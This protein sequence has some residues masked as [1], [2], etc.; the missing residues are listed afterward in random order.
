MLA[1]LAADVEQTGGQDIGQHFWEASPM[2]EP[3]FESDH[4]IANDSEPVPAGA[5]SLPEP[6]TTADPVSPDRPAAEEDDSTAQNE[7]EAQE[8]VSDPAETARQD[9]ESVENDETL[10]S[11]HG[12]DADDGE[13]AADTQLV[14]H[15]LTE[16]DE[17][18]A[19]DE[20]TDTVEDEDTQPISWKVV[21][22]NLNKD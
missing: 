11:E 10:E 21:R 16:D 8:P 20:T 3:V 7:S 13:E 19:H 15:S 12:T 1:E 5:T 22:E 9:T 2:S 17:I 18:V 14:V 4:D 6:A